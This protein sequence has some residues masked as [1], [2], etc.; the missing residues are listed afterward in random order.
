MNVAVNP[1]R[2]PNTL[3]EASPAFSEA[4]AQGA[5]EG[6]D[7]F[8][9]V[10]EEGLG[11]PDEA[12]PDNGQEGETLSDEEIIAAAIA[13]DA[14]ALLLD[15]EVPD[16][17]ETPEIVLINV[18]ED[19]SETESDSDVVEELPADE[20]DAD[21]ETAAVAV[22]LGDLPVMKDGDAPAEG[23]PVEVEI[24]EVA[25]DQTANAPR[26]TEAAQSKAKP[27]STE[28][29][30]E[31]TE[32][33]SVEAEAEASET[34]TVE[35]PSSGSEEETAEAKRPEH[36][37]VPRNDNDVHVTAQ[38]SERLGEPLRETRVE[39]RAGSPAAASHAEESAPAVEPSLERS[40]AETARRPWIETES[41][42]RPRENALHAPHAANETVETPRSEGTPRFEPAA[43]P[44]ALN[45]TQFVD[46]VIRHCRL[47]TRPD[48][49]SEM[50]L[51]LDP[52]DL[53]PITL[54]LTLKN[55]H[56][57]ARVE[58]DHPDLRQAVQTLIPRIRE[59]L[60]GEGLS[61]DRF[62]ID[63]RRQPGSPNGGHADDSRDQASGDGRGLGAANEAP[64][65]GPRRHITIRTPEGVMDFIV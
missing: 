46:N 5:A 19:T 7:L 2:I 37:A 55:D 25:L 16:D 50:R 40:P 38:D 43:G 48:G 12:A 65:Q 64:E 53:G 15:D 20:V 27:E 31:D 4:E 39:G 42:A 35:S 24:I 59:S 23:T 32:T 9:V 3:L 8:S 57:Q 47:L 30:D 36:G 6:A 1:T 18:A 26:E 28:A 61:L 10:L 51:N 54:R 17:V 58:L 34:E 62:E 13:D 45:E 49:S 63:L 22:E 14:L 33:Q 44:R 29:S 21:P 52:P 41:A 11:A 56:L 60:A